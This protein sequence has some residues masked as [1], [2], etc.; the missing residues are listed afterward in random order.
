M[1]L[2]FGFNK[3]KVLAAAEKAVQ[4]GKLADLFMK[5]GRKDDARNIYLT[6]AQGLYQ[7]GALDAAEEA[8]K[9]VISLDPKNEEA[10]LLRGKIASDSGD[11]AKAVQQLENLPDL[12]SRPDALRAL[13]MAHIQEH[14]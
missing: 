2:G 5:L 7:K 13:M 6:A 8:L 3:Q 12:E 4:Q 14:R 11:S 1:A 10:H 9:K